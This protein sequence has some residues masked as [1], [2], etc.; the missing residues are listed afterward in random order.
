M[1]FNSLEFLIFLPAVFALFW[2]TPNR[3]RWIPLLIASYYFYMYWNPK[4]V[5]L[6]LFTTV[7]S[8][9]CGV[10]VERAKGKTAV[11][12]L[13][14]AVTLVASLSVLVFFK[15]FNFLYDSFFDAMRLIG[16]GEPSGYFNILLPVGI[17][18]YTFQTASY[19]I[20]VYREDV[21]AEKHFGYYAL[22][23]IFFRSLL[24]DP[25]SAPGRSYLSFVR[26]KE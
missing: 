2:L 4:L 13:I 10:F 5:F 17:S 3:F 8:Y 15:Y 7:V 26:K 14:V 1:L 22:F 9:L 25:S 12:R 6:I 18:F 21:P 20:D 19:V 16:A 23:V 11:R 24:P